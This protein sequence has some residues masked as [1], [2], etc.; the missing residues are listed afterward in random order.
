MLL[1]NPTLTVEHVADMCGFADARQL[2]RLI[3]K[4]YGKSPTQLRAGT[5]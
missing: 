5:S 2:R 3:G 1:H 4:R